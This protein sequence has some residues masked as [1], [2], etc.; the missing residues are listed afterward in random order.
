MFSETKQEEEEE[1][2]DVTRGEHENR[3]ACLTARLAD[4]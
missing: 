2:L 4:S 1:E 3:A